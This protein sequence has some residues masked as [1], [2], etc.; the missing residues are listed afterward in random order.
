MVLSCVVF[1]FSPAQAVPGFRTYKRIVVQ[2][3]ICSKLFGYYNSSNLTLLKIKKQH[4]SSILRNFAKVQIREILK[5]GQP[6]ATTETQRVIVTAGTPQ[7][8]Q[9]EEHEHRRARATEWP[10]CGL[11]S[12]TRDPSELVGGKS[13]A[14]DLMMC[15][16]SSNGLQASSALII[17][18]CTWHTLGLTWMTRRRN[19]MRLMPRFGVWQCC[20]LQQEDNLFWVHETWWQSLPGLVFCENL[21]SLDFEPDHF[22]TIYMV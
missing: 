10:A 19:G 7:L 4:L 20:Q 6:P 13:E 16:T 15:W 18:L 9:Q 5:S 14:R 12:W 1:F 11:V 2:K 22:D 21:I 8:L 17:M 3:F